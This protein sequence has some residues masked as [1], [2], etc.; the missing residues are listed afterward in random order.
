MLAVVGAS[1]AGKSAVGAELFARRTKYIV[2]EGD[3]LW[4]APFTA[5]E[6]HYAA[7][8]DMWLRLCANIA[9]NGDSVLL[10][11]CATPEDYANR[12]AAR[13]FSSIECVALICEPAEMARRLRA[14]PAWRESGGEA[15][16]ED[17]I[18][19]NEALR[20]R[21]DILRIDT[22][23]MSVEEVCKA[24]DAYIATKIEA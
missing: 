24:V 15:F 21:T 22:T 7:L 10:V 12:P 19:F 16:I 9:Q 2:M 8:R 18:R 3:I 6:N 13:Y 20:A 17:A 11:G 23:E 14:R 4:C 1:G 5:P